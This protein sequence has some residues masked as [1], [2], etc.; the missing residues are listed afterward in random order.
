[1]TRHW[2]RSVAIQFAKCLQICGLP[3]RFAPRNDENLQNVPRNDE[4]LRF[5]R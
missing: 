1:M 5:F 4:N 3:R 2:E